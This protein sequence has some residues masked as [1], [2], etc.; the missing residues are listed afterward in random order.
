MSMGGLE[1]PRI[2]PHAPQTCAYT[3]SATSTYSNFTPTP[4]CGIGYL[5][6]AHLTFVR[7]CLPPSRTILNRPRGVLATSTK[8]AFIQLSQ[9]YINTKKILLQILYFY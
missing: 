5:F 9:N 8:T 3:D 2:S 7:T 4:S 1:P 6:T